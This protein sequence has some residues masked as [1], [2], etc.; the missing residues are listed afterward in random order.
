M[1]TTMSTEEKKYKPLT[2]FLSAKLLTSYLYYARQAHS[3]EEASK[4]I[5]EVVKYFV[6]NPN[7]YEAYLKYTQEEM[8]SNNLDG[9]FIKTGLK[10]RNVLLFCGI[11]VRKIKR[12]K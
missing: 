1:A 7:L 2:E 10:I 12:E 11:L 9:M 5:K 8:D 4:K 3:Q 6:G